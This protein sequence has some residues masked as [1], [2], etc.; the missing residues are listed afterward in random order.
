M[1]MNRKIETSLIFLAVV[2]L[3]TVIMSFYLLY[4][5]RSDEVYTIWSTLHPAFIFA[6]FGA[7]LL[8]ILLILSSAKTEFKILF[9]IVH[10]FLCLSFYA[11][12][13]PFGRTGVPQM[14][15]GEIRLVFDNVNPLG[16]LGWSRQ[17]TSNPILQIYNWSR[18][19]NLET[20]SNVIFARMFGVDVYWTNL[21]MISLLWATFIPVLAFAIAK[22]LSRNG[23]V[24]VFV[25]L[26]FLLFPNLIFWGTFSTHNSLGF[27]FFFASLYAFLKYLS[28][29]ELKW[30]VLM[31]LL[32]LAS[33]L[34]HFLP[35]IMSFSLLLLALLFK[36]LNKTKNESPAWTRINLLLAAVLCAILLPLALSINGLFFPITTW[37]SLNKLSQYSP[38]EALGLLAIGQLIYF[39]PKEALVFEIGSLLGFIGMIY[40]LRSSRR[41]SDRGLQTLVLF[42]LMAFLIVQVDYRIIK[43]FMVNVPFE[44]ERIWV[45]SDFMAVPF[46][47]LLMNSAAMFISKKISGGRKKASS[48]FRFI[49]QA[50]LNPKAVLL[51]VL[52]VLILS[53]W[54]TVSVYNAYPNY[55]PLQTTPYEVDA[56]KSIDEATKEKYIVIG[57]P[58]IIFAGEMFVGVQNPRAFYFFYQ[59]PEGVV[60]F[61][62]MRDNPSNDTLLEAMKYNNATAA[63][64]VIEQ[65]RMG[66]EE[67][68]R[69]VQQA[70]QNKVAI[71][72]I[73]GNGKL[74]VFRYKKQGI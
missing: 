46:T 18:I 73:F 65:P 37:F 64:F 3:F 21:L 63:F 19:Y 6:F 5:S 27:I 24:P 61:N 41:D 60:L 32:S 72:K 33:F 43:I 30:P 58:W 35:G 55:G 10:S 47:S 67:F 2:Y 20:L 68:N 15:L 44:E 54:I 34:S 57:D 56:V 53:G 26:T 9:T 1:P 42:L 28:S 40:C 50:G 69:V 12:V 66:T 8:F 22:E 7:N 31:L 74:Y 48:T 62:K 11:F 16:L 38:S 51:F 25:G 13:F 52:T 23:N 36:S 39:G 49:S 59:N 14:V 45:F 71:Y 29:P 4:S 70:E 17:L